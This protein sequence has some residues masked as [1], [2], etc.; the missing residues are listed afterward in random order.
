MGD[1]LTRRALDAWL[2]AGDNGKWLWCGEIPGF[3][4]ERRSAGRAAFVVQFRVGH[5]RLAKRR[6]VVLGGYPAMTPEQAREL[7]VP[8]VSA[9]W[10][11]A[12]PVAERREKQAA[13][14]RKRDTFAVLAE[15]FFTARRIHLR[16]RSADQY[17]SI[18]RRLILPEV[19]TKTVVEVRRRDIA[20]MMDRVEQD[21]GSSVADR[22]HEQLAIFFRWYAERDDEFTSPLI[23]TMKRH[24]AG[25][26]A[27]AMTDAELRQFWH[28]CG[29]SG[30]AGAAGRLCL[31]TA[32]RR[33]ETTA[34]V[35]PEIA[36]DG[37]WT[38][39]SARYKTKKDHVVPLSEAAQAVVAELTQMSPCLFSTTETV[40]DPWTLWQAIIKAG[41]PSGPGLSWH[42]LR[43]T[44]RTLMSRA[45]VRSEYSER[46]LGH[47]QGTV[48]RAYDKHSYLPEK[49]AAFEAL[50]AEIDR[51][52]E[53]RQASNVMRLAR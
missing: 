9:G 7:A 47:V 24:R 46:A 34:A 12:D 53:S 41:G 11:G 49:R 5:G 51:V 26:G 2:K 44:A 18:W 31:L 1:R 16:D 35:W 45:G 23:R 32:T 10:R 25:S 42:S 36:E 6:R 40:P 3:G 38:I 14:V 48:A 28:A 39:P 13:A 52:V 29:D 50:A 17:E 30:V 19:G 27:R 37:V 33:N 20:G 4:A 21:A 8:H 43:K 15:S 22:I